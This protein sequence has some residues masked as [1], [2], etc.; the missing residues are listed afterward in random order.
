[1]IVTNKYQFFMTSL[2]DV[3][4]EIEISECEFLDLVNHFRKDLKPEWGA[5]YKKYWLLDNGK[6][7]EHYLIKRL[8]GVAV[9]E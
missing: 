2:F 5:T 9:Y 8:V 7:T 3:S 6:K 1:M 4:V